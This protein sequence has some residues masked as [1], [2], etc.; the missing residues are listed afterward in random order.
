MNG[1]DKASVSGIRI[2]LHKSEVSQLHR[3]GYTEIGA[4]EVEGEI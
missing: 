4:K 3:K 1:A 2:E